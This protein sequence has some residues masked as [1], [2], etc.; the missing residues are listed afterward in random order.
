MADDTHRHAPDRCP[1]CGYLVDAA[2]NV[3]GEGAPEPGDLTLCVKCAMPAQFGPD[4][5]LA[6]VSDGEIRDGLSAEDFAMFQ[7]ARRALLSMDRRS[8][9]DGS[10]DGR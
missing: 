4:G 10:A 2:T 5:R 8:V 7:K 9:G 6:K 3:T 1:W